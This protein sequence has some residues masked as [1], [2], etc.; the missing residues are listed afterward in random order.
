MPFLLLRLDDD[1]LVGD[2][3]DS[4]KHLVKILLKTISGVKVEA[5]FVWG[6]KGADP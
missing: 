1:T 6:S 3:G 2:A 5:P 4:K